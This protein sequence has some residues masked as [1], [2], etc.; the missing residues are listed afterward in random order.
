[1][2]KKM[3]TL[4]KLDG[5]FGFLRALSGEADILGSAIG[6]EPTFALQRALDQAATKGAQRPSNEIGA[7]FD[8][9]FALRI[10]PVMAKAWELSVVVDAVRSAHYALESEGGEP[11]R[12]VLERWR[13]ASE[14]A[15]AKVSELL[16]LLEHQS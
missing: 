2:S 4:N 7:G 5:D 1:M 8:L 9:E 12:A 13:A 14:A 10:I 16:D 6:D 15:K 11:Y 3:N